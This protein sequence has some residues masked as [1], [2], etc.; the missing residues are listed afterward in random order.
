MTAAVFPEIEADGYR[1]RLAVLLPA[2]QL[3]YVMLIW[4]A[5]YAGNYVPSDLAIVPVPPPPPPLLNRL[6]FPAMAAVAVA[7]LIAERHRLGRL[8][9]VVIGLVIAFFGYLG[10]TA[11]WAAAPGNTISRLSLLTLL[12]VGLLPAGLMARDINEILRPMLLAVAAVVAVNLASLAVVHT[13]PIGFPGIYPH[14][15]TLGAS[16][17]ISALFSLYAL[18]RADHR[19]RLIGLGLLPAIL[20]LLIVSQS[21]TSL[22]LTVLVPAMAVGALLARR[23][24]RLSLAVLLPVS[25]A[26]AAALLFGAVKGFDY[27]NV[28]QLLGGDST[29]TGRTELWSFAAEQIAQRP[30]F[31]WGFQSFWGIGPESPA[32]RMVD[33]FIAVTPHS[34]NGYIDLVLQG[35]VVAIVLFLPIVLTIAWWIDRQSDRDGGVGFLL[36]SI[37]VY[38]LTQ[39]LLETDWFQGLT[40][41]NML[42]ILMMQ[43]AACRRGGRVAP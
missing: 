34:H 21:K 29:F 37:L 33:T 6:F 42:L 23:L 41:S 12:A 36:T 11:L 20:L 13:T 8:Q 38:I 31:G 30:W 39:N 4:P 17:A 28:S 16:M 2:I 25:V 9:P 24:F 15:N 19:L 40:A 1:R 14:K 10:L 27:R 3:I 7:L 18:T 22:G 35:G 32:S 5:L 26:P 43:L